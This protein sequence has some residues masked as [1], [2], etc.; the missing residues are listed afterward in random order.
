MINLF[1]QVKVHDT[2]SSCPASPECSLCPVKTPASSKCANCDKFMCEKCESRHPLVPI[3]KNHQVKKLEHIESGTFKLLCDEHDTETI[4]CFCISCNVFLCVVCAMQAVHE[5]HKDEL[6]TFEDGIKHCRLHLFA[7]QCAIDSKRSS[8]KEKVERREAL[9]SKAQQTWKSSE[10]LVEKL[11]DNFYTQIR[12]WQQNT[13][14]RLKEDY[15]SCVSEINLNAD[16][17]LSEESNVNAF[18]QKLVALQSAGNYDLLQNYYTQLSKA[19][20]LLKIPEN[21]DLSI[22]ITRISSKQDNDIVKELEN[23][24]IWE[25]EDLQKSQQDLEPETP[26]ADDYIKMSKSPPYVQFPQVS[27]VKPIVKQPETMEIPMVGASVVISKGS[28]IGKVSEPVSIKVCPTTRDMAVCEVVNTRVQIFTQDGQLKDM[29]KNLTPKDVAFSI[30][31][32]LFIVDSS[33][34][35]IVVY[36]QSSKKRFSWTYQFSKPRCIAMAP[37]GH[38]VVADKVSLQC[39]TH[40]DSGRLVH[41][42]SLLEGAT[43]NTQYT[44]YPVSL[45]VNTKNHILVS[46]QAQHVVRIYDSR[47]CKLTEIHIAD[48]LDYVFPDHEQLNVGLCLGPEENILVVIHGTE[49][50]HKYSP[51]GEFLG[52]LPL[53]GLRFPVSVSYSANSLAVSESKF[54]PQHASVKVFNIPNF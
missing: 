19:Q 43:A 22:K 24:L 50:I 4:Q 37:T 28:E 1:L 3:F 9:I 52:N 27:K 48:D 38:I 32:E 40:D 49:A 45:A 44:P 18:K 20:D 36:S 29:I 14:K 31:G 42:F 21:K 35:N 10:T 53:K 34:E 46:D 26:L 39:T 25:T 2:A 8:M 54:K 41:R 17:V 11:A 5:P 30:S 33:T 16:A 51:E 15:E 13:L 12:K 23:K 47:G 6:I 7:F